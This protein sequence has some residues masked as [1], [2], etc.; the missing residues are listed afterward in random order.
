MVPLKR[1]HLVSVRKA[2]LKNRK[3]FF[4]TSLGVFT[5]FFCSNIHAQYDDRDEDALLGLYGD[6]NSISIATGSR[7]SL[8]Q[9]PAVTSVITAEMIAAMGA[10]DLDQVLETVPGL[11]IGRSNVG[12]NPIYVFRGVASTYNPQVLVLVNGIPITNL[13]H[14]DRNLIWGGMPV[15]AI[16]RIEVIR[17]PGSAV[18]GADAFAGVINII[19]KKSEDID[20]SSLTVSYGSF[21]TVNAAWVT[22]GSF[23][24]FKLAFVAEHMKTNGHKEIID[25]D[26]QTLL[27]QYYGTDASLAPAPPSLTRDNWDFRFD[28]A[29]EHW[30]FRSGYQVRRDWGMGAGVAEALDP[31]NRYSSDRINVD[32]TWADQL[33]QDLWDVS[34]Q[35]SFLD[36]TQ[37]VVKDLVIFPPGTELETGRYQD[38]IIGNPEVMERHYRLN[39]SA[40]YKGFRRH[41]I[42]FGSGYY[43]GDVYEVRERKNYGIDP[44]TGEMI[45]AGSPLVDVT[46]TPYVFLREDVRENAYFFVQDVWNF[47]DDWELTA[48]LRHD[49]YS[50]FG[51]T[52]NP[53][54]ALV[55][56]T[57]HRLTSKILFGRAFR[58]PSFAETR[59]VDNPVILGNPDLD[60]E[61]LES[62]EIVFDL[63]LRESLSGS[64]NLFQYD[65]SDIINFVPDTG[66]PTATARNA[67]RKTARGLEAELDWTVTASFRVIANMALAD[68]T[69]SVTSTKA[70]EYPRKQFLIKAQ[71]ALSKNTS[72]YTQLN[73]IADRRR[74]RQDDRAPI[75]DYTSVDVNARYTLPYYDLSFSLAVRNLF[76]ENA[77]EPSAWSDPVAAIPNDLPLPGR[78]VTAT[79]QYK[80]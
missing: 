18:Y 65:W 31:N 61:T 36:T 4:A 48:G 23:K 63:K 22:K 40:F 51:S 30:R 76:D 11:H 12:Y 34:A 5:F 1:V 17:G 79:V 67:G 66:T 37:E 56:S 46:D 75:D 49:Q 59:A 80:F 60:P 72:V 16:A 13:F 47:A 28:A 77:R 68:A 33:N 43:Y 38:G 44:A 14:G 62:L 9:A 7:Q 54:V 78:S 8:S 55:W 39:L 70:A 53:R 64:L 41:T 2:V 32:L 74:E 26:Q 45:P 3:F 73:R 20:A 25:A 27:D 29:S 6:E 50:D 42:R 24:D 71:W 57:T 21:D 15:A 58:A 10:T 69:N 52:T 35:V 19:T